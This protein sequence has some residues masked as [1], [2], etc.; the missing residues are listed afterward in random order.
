VAVL[1][2][3]SYNYHS[4]PQC[5][6]QT[7]KKTKVLAADVAPAGTEKSKRKRLTQISELELDLVMGFRGFD[8]RSNLHYLNDGTDIVYHAAGTG[9]VLNISSGEILF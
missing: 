5:S 9:I 4:R 3:N 6:R 1:V 2:F 8:C 7:R